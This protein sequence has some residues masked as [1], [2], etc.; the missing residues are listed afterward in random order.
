VEDVYHTTPTSLDFG[1]IPS[2]AAGTSSAGVG[3]V[4]DAPDLGLYLNTTTDIL[5]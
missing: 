3:H 4:E 2:Y 5:S 1:A